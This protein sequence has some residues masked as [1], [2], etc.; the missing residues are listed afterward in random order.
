VWSI[1]GRP[2]TNKQPVL[3]RTVRRLGALAAL[4]VLVGLTM[5]P[6]SASAVDC[7]NVPAGS[8]TDTDRDGFTD[9]QECDGITTLGT[10]PKTFPPCGAP[11]ANGVIANRAACVDLNSKDVF[12]IYKPLSSGSLLT[13]TDVP[14]G[15]PF[16]PVAYSCRRSATD[17]SSWCGG[18][19]ELRYDGFTALRITAHQLTPEEAASDRTVSSVSTQKAIRISE[20]LDTSAT[21]V[22]GYCSWGTPL[23]LDGCTIYTQRAKNFI[24]SKC[25]TAKDNVTN[26]RAVLL[27]YANF[28]AIHEGGHALGGLT[29]VNDPSVGGY[30]YASS[31]NV[32]MAQAAEY[33][34][35]GKR[36]TWYIPS[37]FNLT[38]DVPAIKLIIE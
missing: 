8:T 29:S 16:A 3:V 4:A 25:N 32:I 20:S 33:S 11:D 23:G 2:M 24:D 6:T 28:L 22:L 14:A 21:D 19:A 38:L 10:R 34:T 17:T 12:V 15:F 5:L 7:A 26:R 18:A 35:Q 9:R 37:A 36:C 30:H 31:S 1:G 13:G 27:A